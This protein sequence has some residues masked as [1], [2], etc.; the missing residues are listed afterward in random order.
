MKY[1]GNPRIEGFTLRE[2]IHGN[3]IFLM[4]QY[5]FDLPEHFIDQLVIY[6]HDPKD[7]ALNQYTG[8]TVRFASKE[9]I[10]EKWLPRGRTIYTLSDPENR[11]LYG[12][13]W[14][15]VEDMPERDDFTEDIN[16]AEYKFT[17]AI[18]LYGAARSI[19]L[20]KPYS[21]ETYRHFFTTQD[22]RRVAGTGMWAIN[23]VGN[24]VIFST[25]KEIGLRVVTRPDNKGK[26]LKVVSAEEML[27]N[28]RRS[29][30]GLK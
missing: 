12:I 13:R 30:L 8:D 18:R 22:Y 2:P 26:V 27:R 14:L 29:D 15:G 19:G 25:D 1:L 24:D 10:V 23:S 7:T 17:G 21:K 3:R 6:S 16:P 28:I 9:K 20:S 4:N 11:I 5:Q